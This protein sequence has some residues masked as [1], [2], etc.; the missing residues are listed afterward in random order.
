SAALFLKRP[1][2]VLDVAAGA[3]GGR[4]MREGDALVRAIFQMQRENRANII[5]LPIVFVWSKSPDKVSVSPWDLLLGPRAWPTPVR[6]L[7]QFAY[8]R[9][10][11]TLRWGEA[12]EIGKILE[13]QDQNDEVLVRR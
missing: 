11:A 8:N 13:N 12:I 4:G 7:G 2:S 1:P 5:L 3:T 10:H 9:K 6:A